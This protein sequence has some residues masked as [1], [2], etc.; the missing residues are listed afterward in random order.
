MVDELSPLTFSHPCLLDTLLMKTITRLHDLF[1]LAFF[2]NFSP[3]QIN[4]T[5]LHVYQ[6]RLAQF[7][8]CLK[9]ALVFNQ[10]HV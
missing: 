7:Y 3:V 1:L 2:T 9:V 10:L 4:Q 6:E 8:C 5:C